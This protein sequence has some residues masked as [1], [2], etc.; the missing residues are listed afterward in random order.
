MPIPPFAIPAP[1]P[2]RLATGR[3]SPAER[4][5]GHLATEVASLA[6]LDWT[7]LQAVEAV[8]E[9]LLGRLA[10]TPAWLAGC[11]DGVLRHPPLLDRSD[12]LQEVDRVVLYDSPA[13]RVRVR[14]HV[15]REPAF[16]RPH[17]H[18]WNFG[19]RILSG[20]YTH[21]IFGDF[22]DLTPQSVIAPVTP[23]MVREERAGSGYVMGHT[24]VHSVGATAQSVSLMVRGPA[25]KDRNVALGPDT[26][27]AGWRPGRELTRK[28]ITRQRGLGADR[29]REIRELLARQGVLG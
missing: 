26:T 24:M 15:F 6:G 25:V 18:R 9:P 4:T 3:E 14:L 7:D 10:S 13:S 21:V 23:V 19:T 1:P 8:L 28:G 2:G 16:D 17:N 11:L 29:V 12:R 20:S 27:A 5:A 22:P